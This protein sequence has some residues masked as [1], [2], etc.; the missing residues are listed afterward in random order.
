[1]SKGSV[2][3]SVRYNVR[4]AS[5]TTFEDINRV[6]TRTKTRSQSWKPA[7]FNR[8]KALISLVY[9]LGIEN[10]S[11]KVN[12]AKAVKT[13]TENNARIR[14]LSKE[15]EMR[16]RERVVHEFPARLPELDIALHTGMRRSEQYG[17]TWD[18]VDFETYSDHPHGLPPVE[19][20]SAW[21]SVACAP[22]DAAQVFNA[23]SD[24]KWISAMR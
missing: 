13:R 23:S 19:I 1:V 18:C 20:D 3:S 2:Q 16:L 21:A 8:Y 11:V 10:G 6:I 4:T 14:F 22:S 9:R 24:G 12:P 5:A 15:E 7:T 17:L